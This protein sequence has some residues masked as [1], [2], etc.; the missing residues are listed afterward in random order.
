MPLLTLVLVEEGVVL[1]VRVARDVRPRDEPEEIV[2]RESV[3]FSRELEIKLGTGGIGSGASKPFFVVEV[4][5]EPIENRPLALGAE[6]TLRMKREADAPIDLGV[7][8]PVGRDLDG[9]VGV[10]NEACEP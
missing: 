1:L 8:P 4:E 9:V 2:S 6:A 10:V 3:P 7:R 5:R